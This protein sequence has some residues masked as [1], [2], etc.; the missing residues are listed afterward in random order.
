MLELTLLLTKILFLFDKLC[1][2][3]HMNQSHG[4]VSVGFKTAGLCEIAI[5]FIP[6]VVCIALCNNIRILFSLTRLLIT[7]CN[8][9][10]LNSIRYFF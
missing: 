3:S 7:A 4:S 5:Y 8:F 1:L 10:L 6:I 2:H 9:S